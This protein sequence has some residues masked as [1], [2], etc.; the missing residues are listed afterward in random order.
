M[1]SRAYPATCPFTILG[2]P[3]PVKCVRWLQEKIACG[4]LARAY[5]IG[6]ETGAGFERF[7]KRQMD[8]CAD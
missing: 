6:V 4:Q 3:D 1:C 2:I 8:Y 5:F 7:K